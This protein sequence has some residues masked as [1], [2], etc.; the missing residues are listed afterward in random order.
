MTGNSEKALSGVSIRFLEK[1]SAM[2]ILILILHRLAPCAA[3]NMY[4]I[5]MNA[6]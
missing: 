4:I 6:K 2:E 1:L 5:K 3:I